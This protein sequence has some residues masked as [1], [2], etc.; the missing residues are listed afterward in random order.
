MNFQ[1]KEGY[2]LNV[3][4]IIFNE[5][6]KVLFCRRKNTENWQFPQGGVDQGEKIENAMLRELEEEVGL[7]EQEISIIAESHDLI[8]Y[9]IP[10]NIRSKVLG[11]KYKGQAQKYFLLK[12]TSGEINLN[13][14]K[15]P[16]FDDY[17]WVPFWFPLRRVVDFKKEAYRKAL[18]EFK[19]KMN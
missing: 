8:Y 4:M 3:A 9:D 10:K 12:L 16:E 14:E 17:K 11:G 1:T 5:D 2:R 13:K 19:D 7:L 18:I 6:K 15:N